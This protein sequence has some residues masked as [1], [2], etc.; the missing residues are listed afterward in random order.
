MTRRPALALLAALPLL[1]SCGAP[2]LFLPG[3]GETDRIAQVVADAVSWPRQDSAVG[4][5]RA[6]ADTAAAEDGRLTVIGYD[7]L[8]AEQP[9]EAYAELRLLVHLDGTTGF[10]GSHPV[11]ACYRVGFGSYGVA[12]SPDRI[13]CPED[14][15]PAAIPPAPPP[16][17]VA[18]VPTRAPRVVRAE[19]EA[20]SGR[21]ADPTAVRAALDAALPTPGGALPP[22]VQVAA[23][24]DDLG[25]SVRGEDDCLLGVRLAGEVEVWSPSPVQLQPGELTCD[26]WT[27]LARHGH[28]APH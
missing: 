15:A 11:T 4:Y 28:D 27:A 13:R 22:E 24:G 5:A 10:G 6:A 14:P 26:P 19:L 17:P 8:A 25:V 9:D 21:A 20:L 23:E 18:E 7:D 1:A 12:G 3:N 16:A 2:D